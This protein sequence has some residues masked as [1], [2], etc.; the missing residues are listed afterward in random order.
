MPDRQLDRW[1]AWLLSRRDGGD[2]EQR[3]RAMEY[4]LPIRERVLDQ[5]QLMPGDRVLDVGGGD[6]L[7][8]F[9]AI[10]RVG[11]T[12]SVILSD[13]YRPNRAAPPGSKSAPH[14]IALH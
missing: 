10:D 14:R 13:R 2:P 12:G 4:P 3:A 1:A 9:G 7:I 8:A 11:K 6:G 5:A